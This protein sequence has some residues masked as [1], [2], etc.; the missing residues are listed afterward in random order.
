MVGMVKQHA[1]KAP[2]PHLTVEATP[3]R[4][5]RGKALADSFCSACHSK[6][7]TLTGG[8]DVSED[9]PVPIGSLV[10]PNLTPAGP[11]KNWSDG[12][13]FRAIRNGVGA[14]GSWLMLMSYTNAGRMSDEDTLAVIAYIRS[15]PA[16]GEQTPNPPDRLNLL[17][18]AMLGA[19]ALPTGKPI[20]ITSITAPPKGPTFQFGEYILSCQDCR[21]CH[22][23][24]L[25][26]GVPGQLGPLGPDLN[27]VREWTL[28]QF[29]STMRTGIDP[30]GVELSKQMP[31]RPIGRMDDEELAAVYEY[32]THLPG[33]Q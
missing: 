27:L 31:W 11:L 26:G 6:T 29:I 12:E 8:G 1:R 20:I 2:V 13:I 7:G 3:E 15:V 17:G 9:L 19:G 28:T 32:L 16:A 18:M 24:H 22:G 4:I 10:P 33:S 25:T 21:E 5:A 14:D 30:N 23:A